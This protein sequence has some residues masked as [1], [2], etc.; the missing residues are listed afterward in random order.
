MYEY[1]FIEIAACD[2]SDESDDYRKIVRKKARKG[3]RFVSAVPTSWYPSGYQLSMD[4]VFEK[5]IDTKN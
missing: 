1:E 2:F 3:W 5:P 4:L